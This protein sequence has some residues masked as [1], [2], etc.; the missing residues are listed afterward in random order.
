MKNQCAQIVLSL[1]L[2]TSCSVFRETHYFKDKIEDDE[3]FSSEKSISNYYKVKIK[4]WAFLSSSRYVSGYFDTQA[5]NQ[6]FNEISQPQNGRFF[7]NKAN[8]V[9]PSKK[10]DE[11]KPKQGDQEQNPSDGSGATVPNNGQQSEN[12]TPDASKPKKDKSDDQIQDGSFNES[13]E[14]LVLILSSNAD[15]VATEIKNTSINNDILKSLTLLSHKDKIEKANALATEK[16]GVNK[17]IDLYVLKVDAQIGNIK[18][19]SSLEHNQ[20][21]LFQLLKSEL[22]DMGVNKDFDSFDELKS[23]YHENF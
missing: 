9:D 22:K 19:S 15:A 11:S 5:V 2:F 3:V 21:I 12:P 7:S 8:Q 10:K 1:L 14:E 17:K 18:E 23:W 16:S 6:Y 13:G 20:S 4:G